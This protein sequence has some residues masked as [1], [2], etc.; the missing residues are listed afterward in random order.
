MPTERVELRI[1]FTAD[2]VIKAMTAMYPQIQ[3]K[4]TVHARGTRSDEPVPMERPL[5]SLTFLSVDPDE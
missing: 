2:E 4:F 5:I 3:T 1:T